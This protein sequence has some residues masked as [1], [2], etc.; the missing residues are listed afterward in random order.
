MI[1]K[2]K[3]DL[4]SN[5]HE[6]NDSVLKNL[7]NLYTKI[8]SDTSNRNEYDEKLEPYIYNSVKEAYIR[9][10]DEGSSSSSEGGLS[11]SYVD[12]EEKLRKDVLSIRK[13]NF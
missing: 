8:A 5:Y 7:V 11:N 3:N 4:A 6:V 10:G 1:E 12:I 13:G 2:L 9:R